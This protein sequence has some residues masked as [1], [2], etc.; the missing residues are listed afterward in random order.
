[1]AAK[2]FPV[3][4][5][6]AENVLV[7][8]LSGS[9]I[10]STTRPVA[11]DQSRISPLLHSADAMCR[12]SRLH[13]TACPGVSRSRQTWVGWPVAA[14]QMRIVRSLP[15]ETSCRPSGLQSTAGTP[16]WCPANRLRSGVS[17]SLRI[18][19]VWPTASTE[20]ESAATLTAHEG[21]ARRPTSA[22][23][24]TSNSRTAS[25]C[26]SGTSSVVRSRNEAGWW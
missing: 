5:K 11:T 20:R 2:R 3:G 15:I 23:A 12:P 21:M 18:R 1:V 24:A 9:L 14:S 22:F 10:A 16:P 8:P 19:T 25:S 26:G 4:S 7:S 13:A 6:P 17:P